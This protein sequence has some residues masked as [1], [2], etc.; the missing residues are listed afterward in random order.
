MT[1]PKALNLRHILD[2]VASDKL[3]PQQANDMIEPLLVR[4]DIK[5]LVDAFVAWPLPESV[6]SDRCACERGDPHRSGT[7]LLTAEEARQMFEHVIAKA[8]A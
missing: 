4:L 7:N 5:K 3:T 8:I 1:T 6:C 2:E